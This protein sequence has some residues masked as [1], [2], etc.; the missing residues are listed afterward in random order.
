[1]IIAR[2]TAKPILPPGDP[3]DTSATMRV[4]SPYGDRA[5]GFHGGI[6]IGNF[7][8]GDD[9]IACADMTIMAAGYVGQPWSSAKPSD[10]WWNAQPLN[11]ATGQRGGLY[12]PPSRWEG[13]TWGGLMIVG[14]LDSGWVA[15]YAHADRLLGHVVVG[16]RIARGELLGD[17]GDTGS[18]H[19]QPHLHFGL[20][21]AGAL[22]NGHDGWVDPWALVNGG[23]H[24]HQTTGSAGEDDV[25][26]KGRFLDHVANRR[27]VLAGDSHFREG[28]L[29]GDDASLGVMP[30]GTG[31][32]PVVIVEGRSVGTAADRT[33]WYGAW[34]YVDG[35]GYSFGYVHSSVLPRSADGSTVALEAIEEQANI[36]QAEYAAAV[37]E[38][39]ALAERIATKD[40]YIAKYPK[41]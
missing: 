11:P 36:S 41:G 22:A 19:R 27:G 34:L 15:S 29:A 12:G 17:I 39:A 16:A 10:A 7:V 37:N 28:V 9:L 21:Y 32:Y 33:K 5:G 20:R 4:T 38:R 2:P 31:L 6:D 30:K 23:A 1:M 40:A 26:I 13:P 8:A 24:P 25:K 18:A 3:S 14:D 35:R